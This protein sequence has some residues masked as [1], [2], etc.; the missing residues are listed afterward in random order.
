LPDRLVPQ[1]KSAPLVH[2][3]LQKP[4]AK[5]TFHHRGPTGHSRITPVGGTEGSSASVCHVATRVDTVSMKVTG[6]VR[7]RPVL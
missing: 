2:E 1:L 4:Q 3:Q 5:A 6:V 7:G